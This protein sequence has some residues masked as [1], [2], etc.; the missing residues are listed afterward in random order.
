MMDFSHT[1]SHLPLTKLYRPSDSHTPTNVFSYIQNVVSPAPG[2]PMSSAW[3]G[4]PSRY[5]GNNDSV[6]HPQ[7]L[8][9][10]NRKRRIESVRE[11]RGGS[12]LTSSS[13]TPRPLKR[14]K[15]AVRETP[16]FACPLY[17]HNPSRFGGPRGCA[18]W[19]TFEIHRL[20]S[21]R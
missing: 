14:P 3:L 20:Y 16:A 11:S 5:D 4:R 15:N 9:E 19:C 21:V 7:L 18:D 12:L 1:I 17:K 2:L 13:K 10:P 6:A 8:P